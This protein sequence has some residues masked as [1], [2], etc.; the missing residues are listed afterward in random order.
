MIRFLCII[1]LIGLSNLAF[2]QTE[3]ELIKATITNYM[4]GTSYNRTDQ[5]NKAFYPKAE[6]FLDNRD[7][8]LWVVPIAEYSSWFEKNERDK[9]NGRVGRLMSLDYFGNIATAKVEILMPSQEL[10]FIDMFILK[11]IKGE[12]KIISKTANSKSTNRKGERILFIVSNAGYFGSSDIVTGNSFKEIVDV[13][14]TYD[15]AGYTVDFVSPKG[16]AVPLAYINASDELQRQYMY[17]ADFMYALGH[18]QTPDQIQAANYRAVYFVGGSGAMYGV[19]ENKAIQQ[20]AMDVYEEHKG[21]VTSICHGTAGIVNLKTKDGK[22]LVDGK[23]I[24]GYPESYEQKNGKHLKHFP[25]F[26]QKT[27]EERGGTFKVGKKNTA[28]IEV[29]GNVI[30]GQNH[31]SCKMVAQKVIETLQNQKSE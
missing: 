1:T 17:N 31:L 7:K 8:Q 5:I 13:Y 22:Y 24:S 19:P 25:F 16:G 3:E 14:D 4:D 12:W 9:F 20:I 10:R 2:A 11:K 29:D 21:I 28:H 26:I 23:R 18:T 15:K 30:T 27:I 6:L